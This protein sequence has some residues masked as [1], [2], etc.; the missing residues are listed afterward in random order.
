MIT[1][2]WQN[3]WTYIINCSHSMYELFFQMYYE[4]GLESFESE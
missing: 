1:D 3:L 2:F 4:L